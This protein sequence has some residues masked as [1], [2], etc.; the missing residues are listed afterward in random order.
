PSSALPGS[1]ITVTD[2][3]KNYGTGPAAASKT[4]VYLSLDSILD[5]G[6]TLIGS[7]PVGVLSSGSYGVGSTLVTI[8]A[9]ATPGTRYLI[10]LADGGQTVT[11]SIE[12]NNT[13]TT[14]IAVGPDLRVSALSAP[15]SALPGST[16]TV[17]DTTNNFA[18]A[19]ASASTPYATLSRSSILDPGDT[20]I[21]NRPVGVLGSGSS[22]SGSTQV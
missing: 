21:G 4:F 20:L 19:P 3:T 18:T 11:E 9:D 13:R 1:S 5:P 12:T 15:S 6:D 10:V 14:S 17:T 16:I 22:S 8:P 2:T 7:R